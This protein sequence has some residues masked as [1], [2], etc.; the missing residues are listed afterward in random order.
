[1]HFSV[2]V[3]VKCNITEIDK[4]T[5]EASAIKLQKLSETPPPPC[6]RIAQFYFNHA[7]EQLRLLST[8]FVASVSR[9]LNE[10]MYPYA[11]DLTDKK[12]LAFED[13]TESI[14]DDWETGTTKAIHYGTKYYG[15]HDIEGFVVKDDIV[16]EKTPDGRLFRSPKAQKMT[17]VE[18][19]NNV[20]WKTFVAYAKEHS[21]YNPKTKKCGYYFNP[22]CFYDW[23]V[24][25]GRWG[26]SLLVK[27]QCET[28]LHGSSPAGGPL[29]IPPAPEGYKWVDGARKCDIALDKMAEM[30]VATLTKRFNELKAM[31]N[32]QS[33]GDNHALKLERDGIYQYREKVFSPE[34]TLKSYL[35]ECNITAD[36]IMARTFYSILQPFPHEE[37]INNDAYGYQTKHDTDDWCATFNDF[38]NTLDDDDIIIVVDCHM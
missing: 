5:A 29:D 25:G 14:R 11:Q 13:E 23:Y 15:A 33:T 2:M 16:Y 36:T 24:V 35:A 38:Y 6:D 28:C 19:P 12:Y 20:R 30:E 22:R 10:A 4:Q 27:E 31:W 3:P 8:P 26:Y 37:I 7:Q 34:M 18:V 32:A 21:A 17:Y 1:M 9:A